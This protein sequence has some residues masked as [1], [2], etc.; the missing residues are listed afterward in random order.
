MRRVASF[1]VLSAA[2]LS[3]A[4]LAWS[5]E[6]HRHLECDAEDSCA[7]AAPEIDPASALSA[8]TLLA[9]SLAVMRGRRRRD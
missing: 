3:L 8:L 2:A 7:V 9:G 5:K 6:G 1:I 4:S